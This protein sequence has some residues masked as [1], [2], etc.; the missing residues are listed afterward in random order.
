MS[1]PLISDATFRKV[2]RLATTLAVPD[3]DR[4]RTISKLADERF[5]EI[6]DDVRREDPENAN[7]IEALEE[8][9]EEAAREHDRR[10]AEAEPI[11]QRGIVVLADGSRLDLADRDA[12]ARAV[13]G[14][15]VLDMSEREVDAEFCVMGDLV[16]LTPGG[17]WTAGAASDPLADIEAMMV[18]TAPTLDQMIGPPEVLLKLGAAWIERLTKE[19]DEARAERD[20]L[21]AELAAA[22]KRRRS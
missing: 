19:R 2:V 16:V 12:V 1:A 11:V 15:R 10:E 17:S 14:Q 8:A 20:G 9:N 7:L 4:W 18:A 22:K 13:E 3:E 21:R 5:A 6:L